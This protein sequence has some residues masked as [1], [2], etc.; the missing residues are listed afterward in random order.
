M[1][2]PWNMDSQEEQQ[3]DNSTSEGIPVLGS[4]RDDSIIFV[5]KKP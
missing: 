5:A 3:W 1:W 2:R 4:D